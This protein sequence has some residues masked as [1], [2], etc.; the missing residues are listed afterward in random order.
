M[1]EIFQKIFDNMQYNNYYF[2]KAEI[3]F[4]CS[5]ITTKVHVLLEC[6]DVTVDYKLFPVLV[7]DVTTFI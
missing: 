4:V 5:L 6:C 1:L 3:I 2:F 7:H